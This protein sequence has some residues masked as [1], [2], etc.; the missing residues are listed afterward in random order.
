MIKY[1]C[2]KCNKVFKQIGH[3][4]DHLNKKYPCDRLFTNLPP[5]TSE[6]TQILEHKLLDKNF[7]VMSLNNNTCYN[8]NKIFSKRCNVER[9]IKNNCKVVKEQN[10]KLQTIYDELCFLKK[11]NDEIKKDNEEMKKKNNQSRVAT[12][13]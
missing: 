4:R 2:S 5:N 10:K 9:H 6:K 8:C 11:D 13:N 3:L 1:E 12:N 7:I